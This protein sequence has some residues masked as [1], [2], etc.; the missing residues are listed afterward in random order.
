[1]SP[2][3]RGGWPMEKLLKSGRLLGE[4]EIWMR[5]G[6]ELRKDKKRVA[7]WEINYNRFRHHPRVCFIVVWNLDNIQWI[8]EVQSIPLYI[9]L[10]GEFS[11]AQ[12]V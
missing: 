1:M 12:K 7:R 2:S 11:K 6:T 10:S 4:R 9:T 8:Y 5:A 3:K